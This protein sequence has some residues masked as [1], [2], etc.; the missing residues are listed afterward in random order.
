MCP[1]LLA[2]MADLGQCRGWLSSGMHGAGERGLGQGTPST[3]P[4]S[5]PLLFSLGS[6]AE[7]SLWGGGVWSECLFSLHRWVDRSRFL[8]QVGGAFSFP[9][10]GER[11]YW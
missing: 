7:H 6:A 4:S 5:E 10:W 2:P 1:S 9:E 11:F 8:V 3:C